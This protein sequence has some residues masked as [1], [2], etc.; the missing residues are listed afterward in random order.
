MENHIMSPGT[1]FSDP[2]M[3]SIIFLNIPQNYRLCSIPQI[4]E[5]AAIS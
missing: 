3:N 1:Y 5:M 2:L 4:K